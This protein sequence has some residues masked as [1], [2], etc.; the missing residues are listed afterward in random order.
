MSQREFRRLF[1]LLLLILV[2][3]GKPQNVEISSQDILNHIKFLASDDLEGRRAGTKGAKKAARYITRQFNVYGLKPIESR[4]YTFRKSFD[5]TSGV[6]LGRKNHLVI[7]SG[8]ETFLLVLGKD[9]LPVG[10]SSSGSAKGELVFAG[11]GI[12]SDEVNYHDYD[13]IDV[14]GKVVMILRYSPDGTNP[15][16]EFGKYSPLRYKAMTAREHGAIAVVFIVGPED[17]NEEDYLMRLRYDRSFADSGLPIVSITQRWANRLF[18]LS[19]NNLA[20]IQREINR[21]K[22]HHSFPF[23]VTISLETSVEKV[24]GKT[25]NVIGV[26]EGT[27][28]EFSDEYIVVGAHYDHLGMGGESSMMPDTVAVHNGA[29]DNASGTAGLLELAEWFGH[30]PQKRSLIFTSF[31]AEEIGLLGSGSFVSDPPI[32]LQKIGSMINMDMIGRMKDST[33]VIGG[34][35]TSSIWKELI[36]TRAEELDLTPKFDD[37]GYGA[38]DHQSF[39]LKDIPVLFFFTGSHEDYHRPSDDWDK[40][41]SEGEARIVSLVREVIEE[42]ANRPLRPDFVKVEQG[43]PTRGGFAVILGTIPDYAATDVVGMKLSGVRKGGPA[44]K[45][46]LKGGDIIIKF[47]E[48]EVKSIYDYMYALQE[49]KAGEPVVI[50]VNRDG[51]E[52]SLEVIPARRK[53]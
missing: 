42:L 39:Y 43:Q 51:E 16:G 41:N 6:K 2:G 37:A 47:G 8:D 12:D 30:F 22:T 14:N 31:G 52:V 1:L 46:G 35:G 27:D 21:D 5:F 28:P 13:N 50:I 40:I 48:K 44:D 26:V 10:F 36:R 15:H 29:D 25:D 11:Y 4:S 19:E 7:E 45:G 3:Y 18:Q 20:E 9:F 17:E 33:V 32:L 24:S 49:A 23:P 38:S 53:D 34:A